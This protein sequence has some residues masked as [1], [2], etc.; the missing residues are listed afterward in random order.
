MQSLASAWPLRRRL[1]G[2]LLEEIVN[3]KD[4]NSRITAASWFILLEF[5]RGFVSLSQLAVE[6]IESTKGSARFGDYRTDDEKLTKDWELLEE[7]LSCIASTRHVDAH[8]FLRN[9]VVNTTCEDLQLITI[10]AMAYEAQVD[11]E[12]IYQILRPGSP[13]PIKLSCLQLLNCHL[14][15]GD[16]TQRRIKEFATNYLQ[17]SDP[18]VRCC[19]LE[20]LQKCSGTLPLIKSMMSDPVPFVAKEAECAMHMYEQL[21]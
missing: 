13:Q 9:I 10:D 11:F 14:G 12:I 2:R 6:L 17:D 20:I 1:D 15:D 19:C 21:R 8:F 18:W 4:F 16:E 7:V 5:R 3:G